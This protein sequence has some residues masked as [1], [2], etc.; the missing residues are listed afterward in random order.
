[1]MEILSK[2]LYSNPELAVCRE[3]VS[4]AIDSH[5]A[6]GNKQPVEVFLPDWSN[7]FRFVV[8]DYGTGLS[9]EEVLNLYTTYGA[10]T[11]MQ[12]TKLYI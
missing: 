12:W 10:S 9:E 4:N 11:K 2:R 6:A 1:M 5:V 8:K 3:L 7:D